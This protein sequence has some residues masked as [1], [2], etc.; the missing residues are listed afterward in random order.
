MSCDWRHNARE[1]TALSFSEPQLHTLYVLL[2]GKLKFGTIKHGNGLQVFECLVQVVWP[3]LVIWY[4]VWLAQPALDVKP[5]IPEISDHLST[6]EGS[7][8]GIQTIDASP[9]RRAWLLVIEHQNHEGVDVTETDGSGTCGMLPFPANFYRI[10][11]PPLGY[12]L[13][14]DLWHN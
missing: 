1:D 5:V 8:V 12:N 4:Q 3:K 6:D 9:Q 10:H 11:H 14:L 7:C 2:V 13:L